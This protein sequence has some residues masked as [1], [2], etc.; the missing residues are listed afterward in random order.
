MIHTAEA[1][2][3]VPSQHQHHDPN[4]HLGPARLMAAC[5]QSF[6]QTIHGLIPL[7]LLLPLPTG[8][9]TNLDPI[10]TFSCDNQLHPIDNHVPL[11]VPLFSPGSRDSTK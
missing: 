4:G 5:N 9:F 10:Q 3:H 1:S 11:P 6:T 8:H 7:T 2:S